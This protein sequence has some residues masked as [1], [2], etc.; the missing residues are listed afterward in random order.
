MKRSY[1][2]LKQREQLENPRVIPAIYNFEETQPASLELHP[3]R[4][5]MLDKSEPIVQ[6]RP[7]ATIGPQRRQRGQRRKKTPFENELR[8]AQ[9]DKEKAEAKR[10][11]I[12]GRNRERQ[13]RLDEK[14]RFRKE[15]AKAR[16]GGK[17]GQRKLGRESK[18][19]LEKVKRSI[20]K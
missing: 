18:V 5:A 17:S 2:K 8:L 15:L 7:E 13:E 20:T 19:L 10:Q 3:E 9:Q 1:N 12:E 16:R 4:Q 6:D 14:E 11:E